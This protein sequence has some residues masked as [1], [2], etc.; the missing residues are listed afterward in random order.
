M[1]AMEKFDDCEMRESFERFEKAAMKGHEESQWIWNVVKDMEFKEEN[2]EAIEKAFAE[3]ESPLGFYFAGRFY[4]DWSR[5]RFDY[6]KQSS[7]GGCSWGQVEY[8][9]YFNSNDERGFV[10]E[11]EKMYLELLEKA[12]AQNNPQGFYWRGYNHGQ[13]EDYGKAN[14]YYH[15]AP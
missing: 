6:M 5:E 9:R 2:M 11:D 7:D 14:F 15:R 13:E 12:A 8:G 1:E 4:D 3:T 10:E